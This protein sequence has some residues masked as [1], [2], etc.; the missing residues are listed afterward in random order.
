MELGELDDPDLTM[1]TD[2][3]TARKIF[4]DQDQAAGMQAF[5]SGKIKVQ[6]DM[7]KMMALQ[8]AMPRTRPPRRSPPRSRPSPSPEPRRLIWVHSRVA[9]RSSPARGAASAASTRCCSPSEGAKVVVNDLGGTGDGV[10][11]DATPAQEVVAEIEAMGGEAIANGDDVADWEGSQRLVNAAI[12]RFGDLHV[13]VNN[14]GILRDRMIVNMTEAEW[15]AV[16]RVHLRGHFLPLKW[17]AVYWREQAKAGQ[18]VKRVGDQHQFDLRTAGATP[19]RRTTARRR[20][21][22]PR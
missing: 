19:A 3:A 8:T 22:S 2:Y 15:D 13:L 5:M 17:A 11:S 16:I 6:G 4:V 10:G 14:A 18:A 7:M 12:E 1:T 21:A 20:P 9:L